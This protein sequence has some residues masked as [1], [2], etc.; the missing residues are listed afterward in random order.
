[1][2]EEGPVIT[3]TPWDTLAAL[4]LSHTTAPLSILIILRGDLEHVLSWCRTI[5]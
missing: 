5:G 3:A 2:L 1:M 4:G